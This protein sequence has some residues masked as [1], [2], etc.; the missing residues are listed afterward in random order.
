M[1]RQN[2]AVNEVMG[3]YNAA[4]ERGCVRSY[5]TLERGVR[6]QWYAGL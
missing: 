1:G 4:L 2:A 5:G 3:H 6:T